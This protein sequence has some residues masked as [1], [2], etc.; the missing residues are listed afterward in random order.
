MC[1]TDHSLFDHDTIADVM[2]R[3]CRHWKLMYR[4]RTPSCTTVQSLA[5]SV[6]L[7]EGNITQEPSS[8]GSLTA[9]FVAL[10]PRYAA[11]SRARI[12]RVP[13][14][15][16]RR[17]HSREPSSTNQSPE[18]IENTPKGKSEWLPLR[19]GRRACSVRGRRLGRLPG[20]PVT[21]G[22]RPAPQ[23]KTGDRRS[24]T[25]LSLC[26]SP[27]DFSTP[28]RVARASPASPL[29]SRSD[30]FAVLS[31]FRRLTRPSAFPPH[32]AP[33]CLI[34]AVHFHHRAA[35]ICSTC[36]CRNSTITH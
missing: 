12:S 10:I 36:I 34:V 14:S 9:A 8:Q 2:T 23:K 7:L 29:R 3:R 32:R 28:S 25:P 18:N 4:T 31:C 1:F 13:A 30:H 26:S 22:S 24:R 21:S 17:V 20:Q 6:A 5:Q 15:S 16:A 33:T 35:R 11:S 27:L 19:F